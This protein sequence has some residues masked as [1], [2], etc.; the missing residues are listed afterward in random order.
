MGSRGGNKDRDGLPASR[1]RGSGSNRLKHFTWAWFSTTMGTGSLANVLYQTPN[2]FNGLITIGK[3]VFIIDLVLFIAFVMAIALRFRLSRGSLWRS[4]TSSQEAFY[5]GTF[6]VSVSLILQAASSYG[7][8]SG[9][10]PWLSKAM[11]IC[12]WIYCGFSLLFAILQYDILFVVENVEIGSMT[13]AW[14]LPMYPL[15][16][17]GPLAGVL[18]QHPNPGAG[19]RMLVAGIALQGL[20]WMVTIFLYAIWVIRLFSENLPPPSQR[21]GMYVAVGPTAYT[22]QGLISLSLRA[23]KVLPRHFLGVSTISAPEVLQVIGSISGIFL[24]LLAFWYFAITTISV[25]NG[26]RRMSFTLTWWG[27]VFPNAGLTLATMQIA[28]VLDSPAIEW[29]S[30]VM[31]AVLSA[32]WLS[33]GFCH[34]RAVWKGQILAEGKDEDA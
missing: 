7:H 31:T 29:V 17:T 12:F 34:V 15:L 1:S 16:V 4:F 24:W 30:S 28:K 26:A 19:E 32:A 25:L 14:I 10:G 9:C 27:F 8:Y 18:L 23:T 22:S 33:V 3:V 21:P 2:K 6:W 11:E 20:G 13:P 5:V